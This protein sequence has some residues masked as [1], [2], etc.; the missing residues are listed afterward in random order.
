[1]R[2][3]LAGK[4][5]MLDETLMPLLPVLLALLDVPVDDPQWRDLDPPQRRQ[6]T[7]EAV[8]RLLLRESQLQPLLLLFEDLHWLDAGT[9]AFLDSLLES[10]PT[11]PVLLLVNYRPEYQHGWGSKTYYTQLR[12]GPLPP[13]SAE[14]LLQ[15]L[16][17]DDPGMQALKH[18]LIERTEGNPFFLEENVRTLV[19]TGALVGERGAYRLVQ[20]LQTLQMPPTVQAV[21][22]AR[23][24][25]LPPEEK[26]LLQMAAVIGKDVPFA[27]LQAI[28]EMPEDALR[29]GL[30]HLQ[31]AEFLYETSLFP[32][33]EYTFK[34][35]LTHEVAYGGILHE[36][37][38]ALHARIVEVME[39]RAAGRLA[40]QVE[41]LAHHAV[42]GEVWE[43]VLLYC[44][45]AGVKALARSANREAVAYFEQALAALTRLPDS[46]ER[47][48][49]AIDLRFDL[50][51][52][53]VPIAELEQLFEYLR[54]VELLAEA[55]GDQR[56]L[57]RAL[58]YMTRAFWETGDQEHALETGQ[59]AFALANELSDFSLQIMAHYAL[60][61]VHSALGN[62][63]QAIELLSKNADLL[64]GDLRRERFG[65]TGL[66]S[67]SSNLGLSEALTELGEFGEAMAFGEEA[68]RIAEEVDHLYSRGWAYWGMGNLYLYKGN[69]PQAISVLERSFA[70]HQSAYLPLHAPLV[71]SDLGAAFALSGRIAEALPLL[72][73]AVEQGLSGRARVWLP[74][75]II[76]LGAG[77]LLAG[78]IEA[79]MTEAQR[80]LTLARDSKQRGLE[81]WALR[82]LGQV[83]A[84]QEFPTVGLAEAHY[85]Q[86]M[87]VA[88]ELKMRPLLAHCHLDLG[89]LYRR[90]GRRAVA[91]AE[92]SAAI[93]LYRTMEM[94]FWLGRA[95]AELA[96]VE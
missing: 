62:Y 79:A 37:R 66:A 1:M 46:R 38:R 71:A 27:L 75:W 34:H 3:K 92:L 90:R 23:I 9:Q 88:D 24:D 59:R 56:R 41:Q 33:L 80:A 20:D 89:T 28:T 31:A 32:E 53:L 19:E 60:G 85:R 18:L 7:L 51:P 12:L 2:E 65:L 4:L 16:L 61:R 91:Q 94:T 87:A 77:Y 8:K 74:R 67:V 84:R 21:L 43:K 93:E 68:I 49:Q 6:Q 70:L 76:Q 50:R 17:G 39:Q 82:L 78:R 35:A 36:R 13:E 64:Q 26:R 44:R 30:T 14:A 45:Q 57:G 15:A 5:L 96:Q 29:L 72:E 40:E 95:E 42:R 47:R 54:E 69:L 22:A 73:Q 58:I 55:L 11:A 25:R 81:A 10:L 86:A 52:A 48:E 83:E 63:H